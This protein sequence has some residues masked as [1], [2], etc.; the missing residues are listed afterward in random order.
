LLTA[1]SENKNTFQCGDS[2]LPVVDAV[3]A[4]GAAAKPDI[5]GACDLSSSSRRISRSLSDS[6]LHG[7]RRAELDK[8]LKRK[9]P[10]PPSDDTHFWP[11]TPEASPPPSPCHSRSYNAPSVVVPAP[12]AEP[13]SSGSMPAETCPHVWLLVPAHLVG[14]VER[15]LL[16]KGSLRFGETAATLAQRPSQC[17][18][19]QL[20]DC[21][22]AYIGSGIDGGLQMEPPMVYSRLQSQC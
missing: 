9:L 22:A 19:E 2:E 7:A 16:A 8:R 15:L 6:E 20:A 12:S 14:D 4:A 17:L 13:P 5:T 10:I 1:V 21:E 18:W 11:A 3:A